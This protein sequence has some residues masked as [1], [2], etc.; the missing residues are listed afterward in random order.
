MAE[1]AETLRVTPEILQQHVQKLSGDITDMKNA[2]NQLYTVMDGTSSYWQGPA[3]TKY[4]K[5]FDEKK[6]QAD[7]M[8]QR[9]NTYP[10]RILKMAGIYD[11]ARDANVQIASAL[12]S[13]VE[14]V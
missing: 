1:I 10:E 7:Q 4:R 8:L 3:G 13:D 12:G 14:L 5:S 9:M 2:L 6:T 11:D